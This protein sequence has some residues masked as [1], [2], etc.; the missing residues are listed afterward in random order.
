MYLRLDADD[1]RQYFQ[2]IDMSKSS[3]TT[4]IIAAS[5]SNGSHVPPP[6]PFHSG[7]IVFWSQLSYYTGIPYNFYVFNV[8]IKY[9]SNIHE[10]VRQQQSSVLCGGNVDFK[11]YSIASL[12]MS[13]FIFK[14]FPKFSNELFP[15]QVIEIPI[16]T[17]YCSKNHPV[18]PKH[19]LDY[20]RQIYLDWTVGQFPDDTRLRENQ[21]YQDEYRRLYNDIIDFC[22][23]KAIELNST[24]S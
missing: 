19:Y 21:Q 11:N 9:V 5:H 13:Q 24:S 2:Q 10:H 6:G 18:I 4:L 7:A 3:Q 14:D 16:G 15:A 20:A 23:G 8:D 17:R 12:F 22:I 1:G